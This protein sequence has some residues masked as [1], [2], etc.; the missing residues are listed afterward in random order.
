MLGDTLWPH[1]VPCPVGWTQRQE[2][3]GSVTAAMRGAGDC[4]WGGRCAGRLPEGKAFST[5]S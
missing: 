4:G 2:D 1:G 3:T 5:R